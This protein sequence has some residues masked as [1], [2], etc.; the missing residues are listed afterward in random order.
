VPEAQRHVLMLDIAD[1]PDSI[2]RY[3]AWHAAGALPVAIGRSIRSAGVLRMEIY[4]AGSRL[5]MVMETGPDFDPA[6]KSVADAADPDVVAWETLMSTV[7]RPLPEAGDGAKWCAA[8][9]IFSL[10]DQ[11]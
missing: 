7:Q 8:K 10:A 4:R 11:P 6:A 1:D 9:R 5:V 2:A 3:E